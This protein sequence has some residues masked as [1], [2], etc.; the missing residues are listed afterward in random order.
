MHQAKY[1]D[2]HIYRILSVVAEMPGIKKTDLISKTGSKGTITEKVKDL[3]EEGCLI[4]TK[5]GLHNILR[6]E[7]TEKGHEILK[8]MELLQD[9][10]SGTPVEYE[11]RNSET[12]KNNQEIK[13]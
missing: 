10:I 1:L 5:F 3:L 4:E 2:S 12:Q 8:A 13:S 6:Y 7:L 11:I 9:I